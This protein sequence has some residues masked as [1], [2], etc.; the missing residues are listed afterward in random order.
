MRFA[1]ARLGRKLAGRGPRWAVA[2]SSCLV[3]ASARADD[4]PPVDR[5]IEAGDAASRAVDRTWLYTD[6]GG[7]AAP[8][9][10]IG[11]TSASYTRVSGSPSRI[12]SAPDAPAGCRAPCNAYNALAG[13]TATPG[14]MLQVGGEVG[15]LPH[16]SVLALAQMG[17]GASDLAPGASMGGRVGLRV[18][19]L[20]AD[21]QRLHLVL[22]G[23]Y[24]R[25]GWQG[26]SHDDATGTWYPGPTGGADGGW[27]R[28]AISG[29]LGPARRV[30]LAATAHVEHVFAGH[31]D[32]LDAMVQA[33]ASYRF[34]GPFR[35]GLEYVGQDLEETF[36]SG[37][38]GGARHLVGPTASLQLLGDRLTIVSGPSLGLTSKSPDFV[39]RLQASYEF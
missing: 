1:L 34:V 23:G 19:L 28:L 15:L 37:A 22:S 36:A 7:V 12:V 30:R 21:G 24:L 10:V 18:D 3:A 6:G 29:D 9:M 32:G 5:P 13:N 27:A 20:P 38:E 31:R 35:A 2:L 14:A 33:G 8:L 11:T 4:A 39:Y 25:E 17:L 26:P 16:L